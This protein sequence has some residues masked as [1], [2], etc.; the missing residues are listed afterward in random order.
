MKIRC[1]L[2]TLLLLTSTACTPGALFSSG[3]TSGIWKDA[4]G[5]AFPIQHNPHPK[6]AY[7]FTVTLI[8][9]P[10]ELQA[11]QAAA[12]YLSDCRLPVDKLAGANTQ[13]SYIL[14]ITFNKL[15][16]NVYHATVYRDAL[17]EDFPNGVKCQWELFSTRMYFAPTPNIA[18]IRYSASIDLQ[19]EN[20]I[21]PNAWTVDQYITR[22]RF[23]QK[24]QYDRGELL[25]LPIGSN[26][27][28]FGPDGQKDLATVRL[29]I[30]KK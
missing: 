12:F 17:L 13:M 15:K 10:K 18:N 4:N 26:K 19:K 11:T 6:E 14:P 29:E 3:Q 21:A 22:Y 24:R 30:K 25:T 1:L 8:D 5:K 20:Q 23:N 28:F 9:A 7:D 16:D 2:T 27:N